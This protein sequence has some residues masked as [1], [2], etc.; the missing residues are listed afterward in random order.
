MPITA[1]SPST[2]RTISSNATPLRFL[3]G[4]NACGGAAGGCTA[5]GAPGCPVAA[6]GAPQLVQNLEPTSNF[7]PHLV[8][9]L[10]ASSPR[11]TWTTR[12]EN[13]LCPIALG[14]PHR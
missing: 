7:C 11:T 13:A 14:N 12:F 2:P 9:K 6:T 3:T 4:A 10:T 5:A 1:K 8:Q